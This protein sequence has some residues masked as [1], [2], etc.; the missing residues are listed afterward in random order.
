LYVDSEGKD[1]DGNYHEIIL[2]MQSVKKGCAMFPIDENW[3]IGS[4]ECVGTQ[5]TQHF[6]YDLI[7]GEYP[8][9]ERRV[10]GKLYFN[11]DKDISAPAKGHI[12]YAYKDAKGYT[13]TPNVVLVYIGDT[14]A[15]E[16]MAKKANANVLFF[17]GNIFS[18]F[19]D[20]T[21]ANKGFKLRK[22]RF[23]SDFVKNTSL[24]MG[25]Y[26]GG[27]F[28]LKGQ[29]GHGGDALF[30]QDQDGVQYLVGFNAGTIEQTTSGLHYMFADYEGMESKNFFDLHKADYEFVKKT[31]QA[32]DSAAWKRIEKN[33]Q[34]L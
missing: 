23:V 34:L 10:E 26:N 3:L 7:S 8:V 16:L 14:P 12:F 15:K 30:Y 25:S 2:P 17:S 20:G 9:V 31:I 32:K 1:K 4:R 11:N 27:K 24:K 29:S 6:S 28:E 19:E 33:L 13:H 5:E 21:V 22:S 18:L